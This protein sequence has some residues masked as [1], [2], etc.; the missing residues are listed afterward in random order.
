MLGACRDSV[1]GMF[2]VTIN[3][4][5]H[6]ASWTLSPLDMRVGA[7]ALRAPYPKTQMIEEA[8]HETSTG[9]QAIK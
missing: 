5:S 8:N 2:S 1:F 6:V 3:P 9:V 7:Q 4:S